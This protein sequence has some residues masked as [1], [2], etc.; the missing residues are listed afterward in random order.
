MNLV[1]PPPIVLVL[2]AFSAPVQLVSA[3][4][5]IE[6]VRFTFC[7]SAWYVTLLWQ[8]WSENI[9]CNPACISFENRSFDLE[10]SKSD[11]V[12]KIKFT[13][14]VSRVWSWEPS[15]R[16][17]TIVLIRLLS[18]AGIRLLVVDYDTTCTS[19]ADRDHRVPKGFTLRRLRGWHKTDR[20]RRD[21]G[22]ILPETK[23][24]VFCLFDFGVQNI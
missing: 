13:R 15:L 6:F 14:M 11:T 10:D 22:K 12:H 16:R 18:H 17:F 1:P 8:L 2:V 7:E 5:S 9:N 3:P 24:T 20:K 21:H 23:L 19:R 4:H